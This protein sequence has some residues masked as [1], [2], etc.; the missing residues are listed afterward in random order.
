MM[1]RPPST[2]SSCPVVNVAMSEARNEIARATYSNPAVPMRG[3]SSVV[4][5]RPSACVVL[6]CSMK[7]A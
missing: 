3:T 1:P 5:V 6:L 7:A 2:L 4:P